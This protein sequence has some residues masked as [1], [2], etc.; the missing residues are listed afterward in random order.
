MYPVPSTGVASERRRAFLP[1]CFDCSSWLLGSGGRSV[2]AR[3]AVDVV[4][5]ASQKV[6]SPG[7]SPRY[8]AGS[9]WR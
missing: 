8:F 6:L 3:M 1:I 2:F 7:R 5:L 9:L 4:Q